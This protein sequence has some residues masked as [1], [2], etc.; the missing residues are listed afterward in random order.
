MGTND[1][2]MQNVNK[3]NKFAQGRNTHNMGANPHQNTQDDILETFNL[4]VGYLLTIQ[5]LID[6]YVFV[7]VN[8]IQGQGKQNDEYYL[9]LWEIIDTIKTLLVC[10]MDKDI[11]ISIEAKLENLLDDIKNLF[12]EN[13]DGDKYW[14]KHKAIKLRSDIDN[15]LALLMQDMESRGMLT[16]KTED[17]RLAMGRFG[18]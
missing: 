8:G 11:R 18:D 6:E 9:H 10:K 12:V 5:R 13:S 16:Y 4:N 15:V 17:P 14:D 2:L 7:K 3:Q 1:R